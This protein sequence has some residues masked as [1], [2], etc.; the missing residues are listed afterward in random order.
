MMEGVDNNNRAN[1]GPLVYISP[2]ATTEFVTY[3]NQFPPEYGHAAGG[4][5]NTIIRTGSNQVHGAL[6]E[7]LQNRNLN[8]EDR[9]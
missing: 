9:R 6:Y 8:A 2:D 1:P 7:Y 3:Q 4:Q 5:F